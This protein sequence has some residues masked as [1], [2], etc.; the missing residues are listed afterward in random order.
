MNISPAIAKRI[1]VAKGAG[2]LFG[3]A[4]LITLPYFWP[5]A[6]WMIRWGILLWYTTLGGIVGIFG[7]STRHPILKMDLQWWIL[8]PLL[9][10]W[11]N[12]VLTLFAYDMLSAVMVSTF[13]ADGVL[14]S[15]FWFA[16][17]GAVVGLIIAFIALRIGGDD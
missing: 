11:M 10:A 8:A 15:P 7:V 5:D 3:L 2:F 9:G 6:D 4:G 14:S 17:E 13:G 1:A 16:A 12:F